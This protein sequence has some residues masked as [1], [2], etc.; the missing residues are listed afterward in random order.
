MTLEDLSALPVVIQA[1]RRELVNVDQLPDSEFAKLS[2]ALTTASIR[3]QP[4]LDNGKRE[5][6]VNVIQQDLWNEPYLLVVEGIT[7]AARVCKFPSEFLPT[8]L[9]YV[10]PRKAKL[11]EQLDR[12]LAIEAVAR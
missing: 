8:V 3:M 2:V 4:H 1:T 11:T 5:D 12:Y 10:T 6:W 9:E 7:R